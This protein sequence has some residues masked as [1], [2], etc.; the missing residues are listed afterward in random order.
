M[1][2][3]ALHYGSNYAKAGRI[4]PLSGAVNDVTAWHRLFDHR[5][6]SKG[7]FFHNAT[8]QTQTLL[9][10]GNVNSLRRDIRHMLSRLESGD[11]GVIVLSGYTTQ[12]ADH[13]GV[14]EDLGDNAFFVDQVMG[15]VADHNVFLADDLSGLP[16]VELWSL[17]THRHP[18][19]R[20]LLIC[21]SCDLT[22]EP[23]AQITSGG[24][25]YLPPSEI[26]A[27]KRRWMVDRLRLPWNRDL[28]GILYFGAARSGQVP[29]DVSEI[30]HG[31]FSAAMLVA[32][33]QLQPGAT[34]GDWIDGV[35]ATFVNTKRWPH[36][37]F[38]FGDLLS[39]QIPL[40][41]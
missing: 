10:A 27:D 36:E 15:R 33:D 25:K 31:A 41:S 17:L 40:A 30:T 7:P 5:H 9:T 26:S 34:F 28:N 32:L 35:R 14:D 18:Q 1:A 38:A 13:N 8:N 20:I 11:W 23:Q 6:K 39:Q 19:S 4:K 16:D 37:P 22:A 21:D 3:H 2:L 29:V 12:L 24:S